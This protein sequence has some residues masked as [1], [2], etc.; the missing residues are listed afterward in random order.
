MQQQTH[1]HKCTPTNCTVLQAVQCAQ[2]RRMHAHVRCHTITPVSMLTWDHQG[3]HAASVLRYQHCLSRGQEYSQD[4]ACAGSQVVLVQPCCDM[5][6]TRDPALTMSALPLMP[7]QAFPR[8]LRPIQANLACF[9][10][11]GGHTAQ[12]DQHLARKSLMHDVPILSIQA[13]Q[14]A[15]CQCEMSVR[16]TAQQQ[17]DPMVVCHTR[18]ICSSHY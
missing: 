3:S 11:C 9:H 6:C 8:H 4:P 15:S 17:Q 13:P 12:P 10:V 1:Q 16:N 7:T 5:L 18:I 2:Q 14:Q